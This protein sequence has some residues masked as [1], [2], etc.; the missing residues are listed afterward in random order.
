[1]VVDKVAGLMHFGL[2]QQCEPAQFIASFPTSDR[3]TVSISAAFSNLPVAAYT[4]LQD[5]PVKVSDVVEMCT[6]VHLVSQS[7]LKS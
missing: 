5:A 6:N 3:K 1:M 4:I 7:D 2:N